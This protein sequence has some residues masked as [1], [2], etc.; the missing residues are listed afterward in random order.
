[1]GL[2]D[3]PT[4]ALALAADA[5]IAALCLVVALQNGDPAVHVDP[6]SVDRGIVGFNPMCLQAAD[7]PRLVERVRSAV[8]ALAR[9]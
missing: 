3:V 1:M 6:G 8:A 7:V 9:P 5:G 2:E 4:V